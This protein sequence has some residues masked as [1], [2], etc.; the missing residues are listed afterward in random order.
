MDALYLLCVLIAGERAGADLRGDSLGGLHP[1]RAEQR[2]VLARADGGAAHH[3]AHVLRRRRLLPIGI[4]MNVVHRR[5]S[6]AAARARRVVDFVVE[7]ADGD[8]ALF[9]GDLRHRLGARPPGTTRSP[10]FPLLSRRHHLS[11]DPDRRRHH[12]LV[13]H[14]AP[15][16]RP[17]AAEPPDARRRQRSSS[18]SETD[19]G[20][21]HPARARCS[22]ASRIGVPIAYSLGFAALAGAL[23]DRHSARSGDAEDLRRREQG[24]AC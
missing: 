17:A 13:R 11:A 16:A 2:V 19:H 5:R 1:L 3:R 8:L 6:A 18:A 20:Y 22:S 7:T 9:H 21:R 15:A 24:R 10:N 4:H 12:A 23:V 14:R